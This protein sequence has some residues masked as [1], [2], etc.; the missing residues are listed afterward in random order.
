MFLKVISFNSHKILKFVLDI[1]R[2]K[3]L[4]AYSTKVLFLINQKMQLKLVNITIDEA[5]LCYRRWG[6]IHV[7][8]LF[9]LLF[10]MNSIVR[11]QN[12]SITHIN[13]YVNSVPGDLKG[14]PGDF[15][16][17]TITYS[18]SSTSSIY[19]FM[20]RVNNTL[21]P[22]WTLCY[23]YIQCHSP[24][25]DTIT[26]EIPPLSTNNITLQYKTDSVAPGIA[27]ATFN[28]YQLGF[29]NL[30]ED[31]HMTASTMNDVG[32]AQLEMNDNVF[33]FPNPAMDEITL[34]LH[35]GDKIESLKI[36]DIKGS[37]MTDKIE[38]N[39]FDSNI[40][41]A[42]YVPGIYFVEVITANVVHRK[43]FFK[44]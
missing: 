37:V 11:S 13:N 1:T 3:A 28:I 21:P 35:G 5:T 44:Q 17:T 39:A 27:N 20:N 31:I 19:I 7:S 12:Y 34:N 23:C 18:N 29:S 16:T 14:N 36:Y 26:I 2:T 8:L 41:I 25:E 4:I 30:S 22:Y 38:F 10:F 42:N 40:S 15:F 9:I 24:A 32:M 6:V 33:L 43:Y